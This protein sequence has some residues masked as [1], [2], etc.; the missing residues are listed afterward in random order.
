M[1]I[2]LSLVPWANA[3][4]ARTPRMIATNA[5]AVALAEVFM[6]LSPMRRDNGY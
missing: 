1:N 6:G 3:G 5:V 2:S 4:L